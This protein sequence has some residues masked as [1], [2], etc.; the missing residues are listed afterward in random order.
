MTPAA[1]QPPSPAVTR[2]DKH[3][4]EYKRELRLAVSARR[5][6]AFLNRADVLEDK[7]LLLAEKHED[8]ATH[9]L[10]TIEQRY[11]DLGFL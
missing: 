1:T 5:P 9:V 3:L 11:R 7:M 4:Q 6:Q 2:A 10:P 8:V